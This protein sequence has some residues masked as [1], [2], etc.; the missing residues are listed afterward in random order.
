MNGRKA[1]LL[2][3]TGVAT[4]AD[5]RRFNSLTAKEKHEFTLLMTVLGN[6][7]I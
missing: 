2:R 1:K 4:K 5:K 6:G 7:S 3:K